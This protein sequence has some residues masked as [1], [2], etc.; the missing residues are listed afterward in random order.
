L[1]MGLRRV[2][3]SHVTH[4]VRRGPA[5]IHTRSI[6]PS[7]RKGRP[8]LTRKLCGGRSSDA[9]L[10]RLPLEL[11]AVTPDGVE[12]DGQLARHSNGGTL[13]SNPLCETQRPRLERTRSPH[14]RDKHACRFAQVAS[15][16]RIIGLADA[17]DPFAVAG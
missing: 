8:P 16:R 6:C 3:A 14:A 13:P 7:S 1:R 10:P 17:A 15:E 11:G 4:V 12:N 9:L 5:T 2:D